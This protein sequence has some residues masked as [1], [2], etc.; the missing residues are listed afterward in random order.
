V[1]HGL[2]RVARGLGVERQALSLRRRLLP[3]HVRAD[4]RDHELLVAL[5][6]NTLSPK[7][8]CLDVG[9]HAG[10]VLCEL[11][12]LAP[13]GR[14]FAWEPLPEFADGLRAEFPT[15]EV[16][17]AAL[18]DRSGERS[19]VHVLEEPG[20]SSFLERPTPRGGLVERITVRTER[21]DDALP[22]AV[23]PAFVKIDVE[24]AEEQVLRGA[25]ET[26][27]RHRPLIAFEHGLGSAD[28]YGT[29]PECIHDLLAGQLGYA[30][31]G[32]DGDGP[33]TRARFADVFIR[34]ERINFVAYPE[35]LAETADRA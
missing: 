18:S 6:E 14:H 23:S 26:L 27:R 35:G 13:G 34:G 9:A 11:V 16:R 4:I 24:G 30:I 12:R 33:Y 5:L 17:E 31:H 19:F 22:D 2:R 1:L 20:W 32:M 7:S 15:V 21:L 29:T 3:A 10:A 25:W 28:R 8:D